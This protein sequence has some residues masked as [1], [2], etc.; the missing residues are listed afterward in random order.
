[1]DDIRVNYV[2]VISFFSNLSLL[3]GGL[4]FSVM[5][6]RLL[7]PEDFGFWVLISGMVS[8]VVIIEPVSSYWITRKIS[9]GHKLAKTGIANS[10]ILS[11]GGSIIYLGLILYVN[12]TLEVDFIVLIVSILF[13]PIVF[14]Q[15][16]IA[17]ICLGC[18]PQVFSYGRMA[19][20][21]S[22]ILIGILLVFVLQLGIMGFIIAIIGESII[23]SITM[24]I[25]IR[26]KNVFGMIDKNYIRYT[27]SMSWLTLYMNVN[28]L[29]RSIDVL[30]IPIITGSLTVVAYWGIGMAIS[31]FIEYSGAMTYGLYAKILATGDVR[32]AID[33]LRY[34]LFIATPILALIIALS[35]P[36]LFVLNPLYGHI[37]IPIILFSFHM[38]LFVIFTFS[39]NV[40]RGKDEIDV[41][42][43]NNFKS[44]INSDLFKT[45]TISIV[46]SASYIITLIVILYVGIFGNTDLELITGWTMTLL[47]F[48]TIFTIYTLILLKRKYSV[49][50]P[51]LSMIKYAL[52]TI[53]LIIIINYI[54][55]QFF[56]YS[57]DLVQLVTH[58][59]LLVIVG[60]TIYI[61]ITAIIDKPCRNLMIKCIMEI[62]KIKK[63]K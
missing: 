53:P 59:L 54:S 24:L 55:E 18:K 62:N 36:I 57:N 27:F 49:S 44:Y 60:L 61:S 41:D 16:A 56:I 13:I 37:S 29:I 19:A 5:I 23:A 46:Y 17:A 14:L 25:L 10:A 2:G 39:I 33:N 35:K 47:V 63:S 51:Y 28:N 15:N 34:T 21:I 48:T 30:I 31:R 4:F 11:I 38:F 40:L 22:K 9:R 26:S 6:T 20:M 3:I 7:E 1:M 42:K 52:A 45:S 43:K 32:Y 12:A 58:T 8:Y 50:L